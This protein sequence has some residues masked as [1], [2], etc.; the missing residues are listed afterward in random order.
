MG[1]IHPGK[2]RTVIR[3]LNSAQRAMQLEQSRIDALANNLAN[4]GTAGFKQILTRV[5]EAQ[6][7]PRDGDE[8][9]PLRIAPDS[10]QLTHALD[11][12][13]GTVRSTGRDT[14]LAVVGR[15]F[16]AVKTPDG[17]AYTRHGSF[18]LDSERRLITPDGHAVLG[19]RG[20]VALDGADF[21]ISPDGTVSVDGKFRDRLRI[22]DFEDPSRLTHLGAS[23]LS[24]PPDMEAVAVDRAE[25]ALAQGHLEGS[26]VN[27]IDTLV[28]MIAAQRA[29]EVQSKVL[30]AE[31]EMLEKSVNN[32]PRIR[33]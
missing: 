13:P 30:Q 18:L 32:L 14:D 24:P 2:D 23:L 6:A 25:V 15:G 3:S 26:N 20:P 11:A 4:V 29:F 22:I 16:F 17:T 9:A 12:R 10:L 1:E 7:V 19:E 8:G 5:S 27:P 28:A 31:D 33:G 21:E